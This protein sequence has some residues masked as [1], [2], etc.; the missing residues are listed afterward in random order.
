MRARVTTLLGLLVAVSAVS[1]QSVP[2]TLV[3][4]GAT[5][6]AMTGA[7][8]L[9]NATVVIRGDRIAAVGPSAVT[10]IPNG[11]RLLDG[12]GRYLLPGLIEMHAHVSK[13]RASSLGLFVANGV[14]TVRDMGGDHDELLGWRREIRAG[15][16]IGPRLVIAGPYLES[17]DNIARMRKDPVHERVEPFERLRIAVGSPDEARRIVRALAIKELDFLKIRTVQDMATYRAIN[18]AA[19]E[20]GLKVVGHVSQFSPEAV[21]EAGQDGA[22]HF[23]APDTLNPSRE[24]RLQLWRRFAE[25]GVPNVPTLVT[26]RAA[27]APLDRLKAV[28][29][30]LHGRV[31]PRRRYL[32]RFMVQ[33]WKEQVLETSSERQDLLRSLWDRVVR[34]TREMHEAGMEVLAGSDVA[35]LDVYPGWS[36]HDELGLFVDVLGMSPMEALERATRRPAR[37]LG[38]ANAI[39]TIE[40]GKI[41]DLLLLTHDPLTDIGNTRRIAGVVVAGVMHDPAALDRLLASVEVAPDRRRDNWGR[42]RSVPAP[43]R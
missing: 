29:D 2:T 39:G 40:R 43:Q 16:R 38:A 15:R 11:A 36:L 7:P 14:T 26:L 37:F 3:I 10:P 20:Q 17:A 1:A 19:E 28:V 32:S 35:V 30:D 25:R 9:S 41:A 8:P 31:E 6:I 27:L 42:Y 34:D 5:V 13:A 33:D 24:Q 21:L 4:R 12:T 23:F 22:D 18:D